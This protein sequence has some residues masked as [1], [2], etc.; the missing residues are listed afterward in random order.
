MR[1]LSS[2]CC[3][4]R[5]T[6]DLGPTSTTLGVYKPQQYT[7][8]ELQ[9]LGTCGTTDPNITFIPLRHDHIKDGPIGSKT[10]ASQLPTSELHSHGWQL[11]DYPIRPAVNTILVNHN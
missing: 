3:R 7:L 6:K 4:V 9:T 2:G 5:T 8:Q 11:P 10:L 1:I